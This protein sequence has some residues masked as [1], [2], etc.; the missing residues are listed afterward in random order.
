MSKKI[1]LSAWAAA[2]YDPPPSEY[3]L[4]KWARDGLLSPAPERVGK[5]WMIPEDAKRQ[6]APARHRPGLVEQLKAA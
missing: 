5:Y 2:N 4:R 6:Q 1:L 3:T